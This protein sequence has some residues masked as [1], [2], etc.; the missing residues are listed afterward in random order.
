[1]TAANASAARWRSASS[2]GG[3]RLRAACRFT[4]KCGRRGAALIE[5][6]TSPFECADLGAIVGFLRAARLGGTP[7]LGQLAFEPGLL[8]SDLRGRRTLRRQLRLERPRTHS[9]ALEHLFDVFDAAA[10][11]TVG[12][13]AACS[14][15]R[16][17][18]SSRAPVEPGLSSFSSEARTSS[19]S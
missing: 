12:S 6:S 15:V 10:P 17:R 14:A 19:A 16:A 18:S 5:L 13:R 7:G 1:L 3:E 11:V 9:L 2:S 4:G 8:R